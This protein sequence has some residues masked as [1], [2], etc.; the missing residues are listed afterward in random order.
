TR[1]SP[2]WETGSPVPLLVLCPVPIVY[3]LAVAAA[4]TQGLGHGIPVVFVPVFDGG[5]ARKFFEDVPKG[6]GIRIAHIVHDLTYIFTTGFKSAF[7][8]LD[9]DPLEVFH[10]RITCCLSVAAFKTPTHRNISFKGQ[11]VYMCVL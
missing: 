5:K 11:T 3:G 10:H 2:A 4:Q 6:L 1:K 8:R 9:L 7:G